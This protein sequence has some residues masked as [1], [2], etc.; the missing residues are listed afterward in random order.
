M[1]WIR[2]PSGEAVHSLEW[3]PGGGAPRLLIADK[4]PYLTLQVLG[5][6]YHAA[7]RWTQPLR[8]GFAAEDWIIGV[9][10][11]RDQLIIWRGDTPEEPVATLH[12]GRLFGQSIQDVALATSENALFAC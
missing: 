9:N 10:D 4:R 11:A 3:L 6:T 8:W 2:P 5:D 1:E 12:I 7:Y